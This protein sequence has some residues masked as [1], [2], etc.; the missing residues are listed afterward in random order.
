VFTV[1]AADGY[2]VARLPFDP[3]SW[4]SP[5]PLREEVRS[6]G[7]DPAAT[8]RTAGGAVQAYS[9][10]ESLRPAA[11]A[12]FWTDDSDL[13]LS[14]GAAVGGQDV[15]TR[16]S[17]GAYAAAFVES[18]RVEGAATYLYR[19]L[20]RPVIG[21]SVLQDWDAFPVTTAGGVLLER[22][23]AASVVGTWVFPRFRS[24]S[25]LSL[26]VGTRDRDYSVDNAPDSLAVEVPAEVGGALTLGISRIR[27]YDYSI[28][29]ERGWV[30]AA[31]VEGRRY[32]D[33]VLGESDSRGY[34]R[35]S[36]RAHG[37]R[38]LAL[39]GFARHALAARVQGGA[40]TG[41]SPPAFYVGGIG[42]DPIGYP[43]SAYVTLG[44]GVDLPLR[45]YH[46]ATQGG[47]RA[48]AATAEYRFPIA[49]IE[50][51]Y[52]LL[53]VYLDRLWGS[54][55]VDGAA[56]WCVEICAETSDRFPARPEPLYSVGAEL[57]V[58]ASMF[59]VPPVVLR[60]GGALPLSTAV[61]T[62]GVTRRPEPK[63]YFVMGRS[64]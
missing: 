17:Y 62:D 51:G 3:A 60:L 45:G 8:T 1:Y 48:V 52:R 40:V 58:N 61:D 36:G 13:G 47:D 56:A 44:S 59:F 18:G 10:W 55:W 24:Y 14:L 38:P 63:L 39:G 29:P 53:P 27:T 54:A 37:Y 25:W 12:P 15:V 20:G 32:V 22:E 30:A 28:S 21:A 31:T 9:P 34:A 50:H 19:G 57:G 7:G 26:G 5:A 33:P 16:H 11:W 43:L 4:R 46:S 6:P 41:Q 42:S 35:F 49:L 64:F 23:R 2:H